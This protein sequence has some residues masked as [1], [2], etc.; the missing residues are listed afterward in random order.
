MKSVG[1]GYSNPLR[2]DTFGDSLNVKSFKTDPNPIKFCCY[3]FD[4]SDEKE[5]YLVGLGLKNELPEGHPGKRV[6]LGG[7]WKKFCGLRGGG[8]KGG[9]TEFLEREFAR[10]LR[11]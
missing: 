6:N 7:F 11:G 2:V 1:T 9:A 10:I 4:E 5:F 3:G 8:G